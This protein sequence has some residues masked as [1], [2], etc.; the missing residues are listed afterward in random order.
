MGITAN[1]GPYVS[2]GITQTTSGAVTEYNEERAPSLFDLGQAMLDPR[3]YYNYDPG[4][5]VGTQIKGFY[6]QTVTIDFCPWAKNSSAIAPSTGNAPTAG[7]A[8]T[9]TALASIG[10]FTTTLIAPET[11][12]SVSV[13]AID[14]TS[15]VL[16]FGSGGTVALWNPNASPGRTI[17]VI[18]SSNA[19]SELYYVN[20]RDM[21][22]I[23]M[24]ELIGASTTSTGAGQG[25]KA[26]KYI[27]SVIPA[28]NTTISATG[29]GI[30]FTDT[31][32]LPIYAPYFTA[33]TVVVSSVPTTANVI[34]LTSANATVASTVATATSTTPDARGTYT[35]SIATSGT[36]GTLSAANSTTVRV[37]IQQ[38]VNALM[39]NGIT[40]SSQASMF[41]ITQFSN[42]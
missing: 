15:S 19:N 26:F 38:N 24:T 14:S 11:G 1:S 41:G 39:A 4:S 3:S 40:A 28:T 33:T 36:S 17:T 25:K 30:G 22:G 27:Q 34:A 20:G 18:N 37:Y 7:T 9:L 23:K 31:F 13:I 6:D 42:F 8:L 5:P 12:Q 29:V 32:G 16:T 35:S 2:Y 10:T 21:Y